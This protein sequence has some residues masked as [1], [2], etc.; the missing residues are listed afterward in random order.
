[1]SKGETDLQHNTVYT[2]QNFF[3]LECAA[4]AKLHTVYQHYIT[5]VQQNA[6]LVEIT[7][8]QND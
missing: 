4:D 5:H 2:Y 1:M 3:F 6:K 7:Y 8:K